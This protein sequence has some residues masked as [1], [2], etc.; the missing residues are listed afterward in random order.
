M[1]IEPIPAPGRH[2]AG[3]STEYAGLGRLA[4][5]LISFPGHR[6]RGDMKADYQEQHNVY[7]SYSSFRSS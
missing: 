5:R 4:A 7:P 3:L 2:F 1:K 6:G